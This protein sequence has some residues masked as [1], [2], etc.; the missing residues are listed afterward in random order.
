MSLS[1]TPDPFFRVRFLSKIKNLL[2]M[3]YEESIRKIRVIMELFFNFKYRTLFPMSFQEDEELYRKL[4]EG[5]TVGKNE[6]QEEELEKLK[7]G[8]L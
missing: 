3:I 6:R 8:I 7:Q 5:K 1:T 2:R 4:R